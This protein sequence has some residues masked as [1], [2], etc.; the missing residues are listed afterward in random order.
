MPRR[1]R[2]DAV[3][4]TLG[5]ILLLAIVLM[6]LI[7]VRTTYVPLWETASEAEHMRKVEG[8]LGSLRADL[9][10]LTANR[11]AQILAAP[12]TLHAERTGVFD[13]PKALD[14]L[15]FRPRS[16]AYNF[17][18]PEIII[19]QRN[20]SSLQNL[21]ETWQPVSSAPNVQSVERVSNF[22]MRIEEIRKPGPNE[23]LRETVRIIDA[24]GDFAGSFILEVRKASGPDFHVQHT[25]RDADGNVLYDHPETVFQGET[26]R[27]YWVNLLSTS[28][29]F[30]T[31]L[32]AAE[33]PFRLEL[34][35]QG[36]RADYTITYEARTEDGDT[37]VVGA[38][39]Q[40][41]EDF[42]W[43]FASGALTYV[44][45]NGHYTAQTFTLEHGAVLLDQPDGRAIRID[46]HFHVHRVADLVLVETTVP[47]LTGAR[48]DLVG[49]AQAVAYARATT[50]ATL[51]GTA[52]EFTL[53]IATEYPQLWAQLW[54]QRL[55]TVGLVGDGTDPNFAIT[56]SPGRATLQILG[57][58]TDPDS[59]VHDLQVTLRQATVG[60][61]LGP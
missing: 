48:A 58:H 24:D 3:A 21:V 17:S 34:V 49:E 53:S 51:I 18:A 23:I 2:D 36:L 61:R 35:Q 22:R 37:L 25:T 44:G 20:T 38:G 50:R 26:I 59:P 28:F 15:R 41:I 60:L 32:S 29:R 10:R 6:A 55:E 19:Q 16:H 56:T 7:T 8:Q 39:G 52:P 4:T 12:F 57:I 5:A 42:H 1:P 9:D 47:T 33:P 14:E 46:P 27:P 43:S 11:S 13:V 40:L 54:T 45:R 31:V 30:D